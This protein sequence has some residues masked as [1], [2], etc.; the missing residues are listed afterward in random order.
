[1]I[2]LSAEAQTLAM[3]GRYVEATTAL[4]RAEEVF[5]RLPSQSVG[6][7]PNWVYFDRSLIYTFAEE[8]KLAREA[9]S[10]AE[11]LYPSAH[12]GAVTIAL[13]NAALHARTDPEQGAQQ[14]LRLV[15]T[16]PVARRDV[17]VKAAARIVL[18]VAPEKARALPAMRELRALTMGDRSA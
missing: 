1:M 5:S 13:H 2:A 8:V 6:L 17:R 12:H 9:Q 10:T 4:R 18:D 15:E 14:A 7:D 11:G 16:L 3:L